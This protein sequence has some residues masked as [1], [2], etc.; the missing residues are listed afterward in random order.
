MLLCG[1]VAKLMMVIQL[2]VVV[3]S[4]IALLFSPWLTSGEA[5]GQV[6]HRIFPFARGIYE[7]KV[8][9]TRML[10]RV[11]FVADIFSCLPHS[12]LL[13]GSVLLICSCS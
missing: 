10:M 8:R 13:N 1:R 6:L 4:V 9:A 5:F 12:V 7:D 2:G 3:L 11:K